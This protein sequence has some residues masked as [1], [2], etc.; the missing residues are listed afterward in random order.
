MAFPRPSQNSYKS[1]IGNCDVIEIV[2]LVDSGIMIGSN[3][4]GIMTFVPAP[5]PF[6][7]R[8]GQELRCK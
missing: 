2:R 7:V 5:S 3:G 1:G 8:E 6:G 4:N